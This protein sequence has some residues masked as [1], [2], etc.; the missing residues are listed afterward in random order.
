[1]IRIHRV[2]PI[3]IKIQIPWRDHHHT[4][5]AMMMIKMS[6]LVKSSYGS[7]LYILQNL[8]PN[9]LLS[10]MLSIKMKSNPIREAFTKI[11][12]S[13][14]LC[15]PTLNSKFRIEDVWM[16]ISHLNWSMMA[17]TWVSICY[18]CSTYLMPILQKIHFTTNPKKQILCVSMPNKMKKLISGNWAPNQDGTSTQY[19]TPNNAS[20]P[21]LVLQRNTQRNSQVQAPL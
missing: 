14:R 5:L 17:K 21:K 16:R 18:P 6:I 9:R 15:R 3:P 10:Y 2:R 12:K 1:M 11:G 4:G 19:V 8:P 20:Q 13:M 7:L